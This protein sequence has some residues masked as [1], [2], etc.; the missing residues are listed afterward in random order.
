MALHVCDLH[1]AVKRQDTSR[2]IDSYCTVSGPYIAPSPTSGCYSVWAGETVAFISSKFSSAKRVV[3][4][5]LIQYCT[6]HLIQHALEYMHRI[7]GEHIKHVMCPC[8]CCC[9][10]EKPR[11]CRALADLQTSRVCVCQA[12]PASDSP[13]FHGSHDHTARNYALFPV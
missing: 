13:E 4:T 10:F 11:P 6:L 7:S 1:S 9:R 12:T 8:K 5:A 2:T 3:F